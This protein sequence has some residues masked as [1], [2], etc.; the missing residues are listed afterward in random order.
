MI[1][2]EWQVW[3]VIIKQNNFVLKIIAINIIGYLL[4]LRG[5]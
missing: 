3:Y 2:Y 1:I 4:S 5:F